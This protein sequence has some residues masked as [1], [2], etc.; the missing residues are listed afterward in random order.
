MYLLLIESICTPFKFLQHHVLA[1]AHVNTG[2]TGS[3]EPVKFKRLFF[4]F[5]YFLQEVEVEVAI[6]N[7][8]NRD[9]K[10]SRGPGLYYVCMCIVP[11]FC[12]IKR[13][14]RNFVGPS[15]IMNNHA[16]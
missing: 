4:K 9:Q 15:F 13:L 16:Q 11:L 12:L 3:W 10:L 8:S 5:A 2:S 14:A 6:R 7:P 1:R